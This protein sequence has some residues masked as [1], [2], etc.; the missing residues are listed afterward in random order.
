MPCEVLVH[1]WA[2]IARI[3]ILKEAFMN[4][5]PIRAR[6]LALTLRATGL[7]VALLLSG[8]LGSA[9]SETF[10]FG[11]NANDLVGA[12]I[13]SLVSGDFAMDLAAGPVGSGL[14]ETGSALGMGVDSTAVLG[15]GG[16]SARF[17]RIG[18][19]S[20][21]IEFT[22]ATPG[23][24]TGL[25]FDGVKD[26]AFEYFL[27]ESAGGVRVNLFDSAA[28]ITIPGAIDNAVLLGAVTGEVVY[29]L[30]GGGF[31]DETNSLSIPFVA[32][33]VFKL[34][35]LELGGGLG[36]QYEPTI[37]PNG[38][39]LQSISVAAVPEPSTIALTLSAAAV[40]LAAVVRRRRF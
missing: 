27:L 38:A 33:Q 37:V 21:F 1:R 32:G 26:E 40:L 24:L 30:E 23:I 20:E 31:D 35:Y 22:F 6:A 13:K 19:I 3:V 16:Q 11:S 7:A 28:N 17:D 5:R 12:A 14:W 25:N 10:A 8:L 34:T 36:A 39:R 2:G 29:M 4:H 15:A 9:R 18:G